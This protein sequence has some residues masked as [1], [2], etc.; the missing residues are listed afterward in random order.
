VIPFVKPP[1]V[2]GLP[3]PCADPSNPEL[4]DE[5]DAT[6]SVVSLDPK[7]PGVKFTEAE[8]SPAVAVPIAGAPGFV[9]VT[10]TTTVVDTLD[11]LSSASVAVHVRVVLPIENVSPGCRTTFEGSLQTT[12]TGPSSSVAV[13]TVKFTV[14]P[15]GENADTGAGFTPAE[16]ARSVSGGVTLK[17]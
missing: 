17:E 11:G 9:G 13:G 1:T 3:P 2:I 15:I 5:H 16:I 10:V 8:L 6:K 12:G 14:A 7:R 4:N